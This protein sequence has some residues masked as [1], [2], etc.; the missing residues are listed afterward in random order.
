MDKPAWSQEKAN[1][2]QHI[3]ELPEPRE[4]LL[5]ALA[6]LSWVFITDIDRGPYHTPHPYKK[7][8]DPYVI[9]VELLVWLEKT[10]NDKNDYNLSKPFQITLNVLI[11]ITSIDIILKMTVYVWHML[12]IQVLEN[13]YNKWITGPLA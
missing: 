12:F 1:R 8:S 9:W 13:A 10:H 4:K 3:S 6:S 2:A 7:V 5:L 11:I